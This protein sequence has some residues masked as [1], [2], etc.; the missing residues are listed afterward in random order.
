M[1][2]ALVWAQDAMYFLQ[3]PRQPHDKDLPGPLTC[4]AVVVKTWMTLL[5][6]DNALHGEGTFLS[7]YS[8]NFLICLQKDVN[9]KILKV[10]ALADAVEEN[11]DRLLQSSAGLRSA[12]HLLILLV[13][14]WQK[15]SADQTAI[16][17]AAF[18]PL[19]EDTQELDFFKDWSKVN[20]YPTEDCREWWHDTNTTETVG[21]TVGYFCFQSYTPVRSCGWLLP[22]P[23]M[24]VFNGK[25]WGD[26]RN[27][28]GFRSAV[29]V[30]FTS[31]VLAPLLFTLPSL[32]LDSSL[33]QCLA[34]GVCFYFHQLLEEG[35][36]IA[37]VKPLLL[38][39]CP[40]NGILTSAP[41]QTLFGLLYSA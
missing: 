6:S 27:A 26:T 11:Q 9:V 14:L 33:V 15:L 30:G 1:G 23:L 10:I 35:S 17:E 29:S 13:R 16:L 20:I 18:L 32:Q 31:L 8:F 7:T 19:Q 22:T 2:G 24:F 40:G 12:T 34:V 25:L 5:I 41:P 38:V 39:M 37:F 3:W 21:R 4:Q 28:L 36:R